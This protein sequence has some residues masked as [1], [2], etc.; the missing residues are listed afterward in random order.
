M[1]NTV[2]GFIWSANCPFYLYHKTK[3]CFRIESETGWANQLCPK[4]HDDKKRHFQ[5]AAFSFSG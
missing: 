5:K 1:G 3:T 4:T 2:T